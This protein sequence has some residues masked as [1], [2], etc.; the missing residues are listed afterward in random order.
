MFANY[1]QCGPFPNL[2]PY[3]I[4]SSDC[5]SAGSALFANPILWVSTVRLSLCSVHFYYL[6]RMLP[7]FRTSKSGQ[8][9][10]FGRISPLCLN[11]N[12][13][14]CI[15]IFFKKKKRI[16]TWAFI[17]CK[18]SDHRANF[19]RHYSVETNAS[20]ENI[21]SWYRLIFMMEYAFLFLYLYIYILAFTTVFNKPIWI[22][23]ICGLDVACEP[24]HAD[25]RIL[26][27]GNPP[28]FLCKLQ[29]MKKFQ[30]IVLR[31]VAIGMLSLMSGWAQLALKD[32]LSLN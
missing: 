10:C 8:G 17:H 4:T 32:K 15:P 31:N 29:K 19:L 2:F 28:N 20:D 6:L 16:T 11:I 18:V 7:S 5:C 30:R 23:N 14:T 21:L 1:L 22:T 26:N 3:K 25:L 13:Q 24:P 9:R 27:V 12:M